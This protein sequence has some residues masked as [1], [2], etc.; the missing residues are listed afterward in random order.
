MKKQLFIF[1]LLI[2][3]FCA[4]VLAQQ[5]AES[6]F[7][8]GTDSF[9]LN[10]KPYVIRCGELHFAR[11]PRAYWRQRLKMVK[12]VGLNTVCAYLFWNLHETTPGKFNWEGQAD[13]AEFCK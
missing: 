7:N 10:G 3:S 6:T 5:E 9:L 8:I 11:I 2:L 1:L 12:A 4:S 13:A